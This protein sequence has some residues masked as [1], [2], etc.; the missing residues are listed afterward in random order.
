MNREHANNVD[1]RIHEIRSDVKTREGFAE[2]LKLLTED[3][4][5][6]GQ[7][8]E[9][10]TLGDYLEGM[11]GWL[12]DADGYYTNRGIVVD[13]DEPSWRVLTDIL[14]AARVYE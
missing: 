11:S 4:K 6:N 5:Q 3:F 8:W 10:K 12:H 2:I 13:L 14:L 9:N 7:E 1:E